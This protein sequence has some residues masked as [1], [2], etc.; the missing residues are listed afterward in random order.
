MGSEELD[1][2]FVEDRDWP[3]KTGT[4]KLL[5][6]INELRNSEWIKNVEDLR[7]KM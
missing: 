1:E 2:A 6:K 3:A 7:G 4:V 5:S